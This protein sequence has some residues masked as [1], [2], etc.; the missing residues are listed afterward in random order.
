MFDGMSTVEFVQYGPVQRWP[1]YTT[2]TVTLTLNL[3]LNLI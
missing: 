3:T 1:T 2:L